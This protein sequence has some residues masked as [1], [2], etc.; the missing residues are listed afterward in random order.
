MRR[1][2]GEDGPRA[3]ARAA[4]KHARVGRVPTR[5]EGAMDRWLDDVARAVAGG[6]S[7]RQAL[8]RI[9]GGI[10]G[11]LLARL[12]PGDAGRTEARPGLAAPGATGVSIRLA[13]G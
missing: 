13:G 3:G 1:T 7:R 8:R 9:G 4:A 12:L 10:A 5:G 2:T 6:M 11:A